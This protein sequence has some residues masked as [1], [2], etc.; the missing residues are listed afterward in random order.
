[1]SLQPYYNI[2][3]KIVNFYIFSNTHVAI[4]ASL[5]VKITLLQFNIHENTT[6][7]FVFFATLLSYN[8]IRF[9]RLSETVNWYNLWV[10]KYKKAL[11][12]IS[13]ISFIVILYLSLDLKIKSLLLLT[14]FSLITLFYTFPLKKYEL[15]S[16]SG[17]KLLLIAVSWAGITVLFPLIEYDIP[18]N[19]YALFLQRF[20]FIIAITIP[21]DIRDLNYDNANLKTLPQQ[22]GLKKTKYVG[23]L[24]LLL[25]CGLAFFRQHQFVTTCIITVL[26]TLLLMFSTD[27]QSKYYSAFFVEAL[28]IVWYGLILIYH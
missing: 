5:L 27:K 28:P 22:L 23:L 11:Y 26:S 14:P 7:W 1:M 2:F 6:V 13:G 9:I 19:D 10:L 3:I 17:L 16:I 4:S 20:L 8:I 21:F 18:L 15:R 24:A 25:F 12:L